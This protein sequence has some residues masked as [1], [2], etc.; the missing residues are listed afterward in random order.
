MFLTKWIFLTTA[1]SDRSCLT[2]GLL[3]IILLRPMSGAVSG[4][5]VPSCLSV[6][7]RIAWHLSG[8][9]GDILQQPWND[10]GSFWFWGENS[11]SNNFVNCIKVIFAR[12]MSVIFFLKYRHFNQMSTPVSR[13]SPHQSRSPGPGRSYSAP[14]Q[15]QAKCVNVALI[16]VLFWQFHL[17]F[18]KTFEASKSF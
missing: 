16:L 10:N 9:Q 17:R 8:R 12:M 15:S 14:A 6:I 1:L 7:T 4:L 11:L 3:A 5:R 2:I 18:L 13:P